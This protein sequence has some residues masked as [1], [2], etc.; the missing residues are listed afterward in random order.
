VAEINQFSGNQETPQHEDS[1][2][3]AISLSGTKS[4]LDVVFE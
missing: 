3:M 1:G 4:D 2:E